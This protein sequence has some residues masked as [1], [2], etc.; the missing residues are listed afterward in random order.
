MNRR[1]ESGFVPTRRKFLI[2]TTLGLGL[3]VAGPHAEPGKRTMRVGI[4]DNLPLTEAVKSRVWSGFDQAMRERGWVEGDNIIFERRY[5]R[6]DLSPLPGVLA[7]LVSLNV[8]VIVTPTAPAAIAAKKATDRIPIVFAVGDAVGRG[9]VATLAHPGGNAT[10]TSMQFVEIQA[11]RIELLQQLSPGIARVAV[12]MNTDVGFPPAMLQE[13]R[14]HGVEIFIVELRGPH[15]LDR[16]LATIAKQRADA[17]LHSQIWSDSQFRAEIV[18]AI[19]RLRLPAIFP[20]RE[21]VDIGGLLSYGIEWGPI[22]GQAAVYVDKIL[23]GALPAD[24]P[25]EQ[26]TAFDLAINLKTAKALGVAV[27]RELLVRADWIVE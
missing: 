25:V 3:F 2:G 1:P 27:P 5:F 6:G 24:L 13:P 17:V 12:F 7:E 16:A 9:L 15:D 11:K 26:P 14:P 22:L 20:T 23:R 21:Y 18:E 19:A 4:V 8:D 10:G